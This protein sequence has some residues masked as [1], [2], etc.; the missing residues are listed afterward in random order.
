MKQKVTEK[1]KIVELAQSFKPFTKRFAFAAFLIVAPLLLNIFLWKAFVKPAQEK[2][3]T[4]QDMVSLIRMKPNLELLVQES[5]HLL[6]SW[7]E[8]PLMVVKE[9]QKQ[10]GNFHVQIKEINTADRETAHD[11]K[12]NLSKD[13]LSFSSVPVSLETA[14]SYN[15]LA[16]WL[17]A[18]ETKSGLQIDQWTLLPPSAQ[19]GVSRLSVKMKVILTNQ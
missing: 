4:L 10:A 8:H 6:A 2:V 17:N 15:K 11:A 1:E 14:G 13:A 12:G 16:S 18:I 9:I 3:R 19:G 5:D 7:Q